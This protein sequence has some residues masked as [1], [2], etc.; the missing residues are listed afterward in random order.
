MLRDEIYCQICKQLTDNKSE[1]STARLWILMAL[2]ASVFQATSEEFSKVLR[3]FV[4]RGPPVYK[5]FVVERFKRAIE[6]PLREGPPCALEVASAFAKKP[7]KIEIDFYAGN[8][9]AV[10]V[11]TRRCAAE[12]NGHLSD[13]EFHFRSSQT[14]TQHVKICTQV[15][16]RILRSKRFVPNL[17]PSFPSAILCRSPKG[18]HRYTAP[19]SI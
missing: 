19:N 5:T 1:T 10:S 2:C 4:Q 12:R 6:N 18:P 3:I 13:I 11:P 14:H 7:I 8:L 16:L 15:S 9:V 17:C